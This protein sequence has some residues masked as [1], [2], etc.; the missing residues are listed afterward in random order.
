[1]STSDLLQVPSVPQKANFSGAGRQFESPSVMFCLAQM[2]KKNEV[3][4][5]PTHGTA[6]EPSMARREESTNA[7]QA[8]RQVY[9]QKVRA[10]QRMKV[11]ADVQ[12]RQ[13]HATRYSAA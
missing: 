9:Q 11:A 2:K 10:Y 1:M 7:P 3:K 5:Y 12:E 4:T 6:P 13:P 8:E